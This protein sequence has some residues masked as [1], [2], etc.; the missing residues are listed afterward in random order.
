MPK[1]YLSLSP[2]AIEHHDHRAV[3]SAVRVY[4]FGHFWKVCEVCCVS[5]RWKIF[6]LGLD[7]CI[8]RGES[9]SAIFQS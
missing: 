1:T 9:L 7:F 2:E 5:E 4:S 3:A 6:S 8:S